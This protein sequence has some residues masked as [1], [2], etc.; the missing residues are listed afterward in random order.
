MDPAIYDFNGQAIMT[1]GRTED[2]VMLA[3][4][5]PEKTRDKSFNPINNVLAD[6]KPHHYSPLTDQLR[7]PA[8]E[9]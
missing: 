2:E 1:A 5:E 3:T 8:E 6:R 9:L 4:I 7:A